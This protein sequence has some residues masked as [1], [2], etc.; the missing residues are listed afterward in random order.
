MFCCG[1]IFLQPKYL[2]H[3]LCIK[4]L[5]YSIGHNIINSL[6]KI[7]IPLSPPGETLGCD[8]VVTTLGE[9]V[10]CHK[11]QFNIDTLGKQLVVVTFIQRYGL[12]RRIF[13]S[14][15]IYPLIIPASVSGTNSKYKQ[16]MQIKHDK[17][18]HKFIIKTY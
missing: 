6:F 7:L 9:N 18:M 10:L 8:K 15:I 12:W 13:L 1:K 4:S 5:W 16:F 3:F 11:N 17:I 14:A 2:H